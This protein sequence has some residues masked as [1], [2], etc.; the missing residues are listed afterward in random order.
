MKN[1][2]EKLV[3]QQDS[4]AIKDGKRLAKSIP[5]FCPVCGWRN[6]CEDCKL[7]TEEVTNG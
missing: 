7:A 2:V 4:E 3:A 6:A 5:K 1:P